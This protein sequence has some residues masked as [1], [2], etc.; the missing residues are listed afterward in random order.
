MDTLSYLAE[1]YENYMVPA[2]FAPWSTYL[3]Q[4]ANPQPGEHVL[5]VACGTGIVT[6]N[7]APRV[8]SKGMVIGI[9]LNPNMISM[10]RVA[11]ER[12]GLTIEWHLTPA[13]NLPFPDGIFDLI[14][15]QFGLMFFSDQHASLMEMNRVLRPGGRIVLSVW[16]GL[17]RHPFYQ[18]LHDVSSRLLGKSTVQTVFSL[19]NPD[20]LRKLLTDSGFQQIEIEPMSIMTH[21]P[22]AEEFLAWES[23]V[24]PAECPK[25]QNLD[26]ESQQAIL[27]ALRQEMQTPLHEVMQ[28]DKVVFRSYTY[29][30]YASR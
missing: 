6:R 26:T 20:E 10:A 25:L 14:L 9:D 27:A 1:S 8:G 17:E 18:K 23:D 5:D 29:I 28:G 22:N 19:G 4:R 12:E 11:A 13:E 7:V 3:I 16:Q 30:A 21:F 2:L 15:C 24:D